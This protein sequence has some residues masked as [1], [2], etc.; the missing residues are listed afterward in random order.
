MMVLELWLQL[1]GTFNSAKYIGIL[2]K[3]L[4]PEVVWY[5]VGKEY[6]FMDD[7]APVHR[8][9]TVDNYKDQNEATSTEWPASTITRFKYNRK[10]LALHEERATKV[11]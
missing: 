4:W 9:H 6:L 8:A 1:T 7:N 10:Y 11:W 2:D 3:S 5:F